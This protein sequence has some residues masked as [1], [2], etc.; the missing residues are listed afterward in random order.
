M[1]NGPKPDAAKVRRDSLLQRNML[2]SMRLNNS[3]NNENQQ[4]GQLTSE[5]NNGNWRKTLGV[6]RKLSIRSSKV[7][8]P[9]T[10]KVNN[11]T[12][13]NPNVN[14]KRYSPQHSPKLN[15]K[16]LSLKDFEIGKKLG[17]GKFGRVYCVRHKVTGFICAMKVME[18]QEIMQYNVQKQF[19]REVEIQSSL[20]HQNLTKLYGYFHDDK[21]VYLLMEYLV[22]GELYKLL[23]AKGPLDD[24]FASHYV[25]QMADALDYMHQRNIIHRD[26]KP[27][28]ILIGFD[29]T[30]K[31]TDFGWSIINPRGTK[32]KTMCGTL[33]YLSPELIASKE[34]DDKVD[35]WALGVL[36]FELV[37]NSPPFEED[38]KE[39]TSKRIVR[40]DL[41]FPNHI[42]SD[43]QDL[44]TKLLR[45]NSKDRI[46]LREVKQHPW[47][48]KN[49]PFW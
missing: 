16:S 33:D 40:G 35:V 26:V 2:L 31:L 25:Y 21:R 49:R 47:I 36:T 17:K 29:N 11:T 15:L 24:I 8:S 28:N 7:G 23:R 1:S 45:H 10:G 38:S 32:R 43:A 19:R 34:Y 9:I 44:I 12:H 30:V 22:N 46:S 42:S 13:G 41:K 18:K 5:K 14:G 3:G 27:E 6:P 37:V 20:N 4:I 48:T 39:L